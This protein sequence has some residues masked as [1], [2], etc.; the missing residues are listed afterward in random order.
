MNKK[1]R[2]DLHVLIIY[3][4]LELLQSVLGQCMWN[5]MLV[6]PVGC[7]EEYKLYVLISNVYQVG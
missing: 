3:K 5:Y 7:N 4:S 1:T 2:E 6:C